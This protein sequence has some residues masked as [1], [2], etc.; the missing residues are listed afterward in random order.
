M[1]MSLNSLITP[2]AAMVLLAAAPSLSVSTVVSRAASFGFAHGLCV[3]VGIVIADLLFILIAIFGLS[4][5]V[6]SMG[7]LFYLVKYAGAAYLIWLGVR[8][9][10]R[11]NVGYENKV[12]TGES[13]LSST[14]AGLLVTLADQK[15][16]LF[17]LGFLPAFIDLNTVTAMDVGS[18][19]LIATLAV[20]GVKL[21]YAYMA[22]KIAN[23]LNSRLLVMSNMLAACVMMGVGIYLLISA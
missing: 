3:T 23:R 20:G 11:S 17:Y 6:A 9:W 13:Y 16:I 10:Q 19:L 4:L 8:L 7:E 18:I 5:L 12:V 2:F 15:A 21:V 14:M 1:L 22:S